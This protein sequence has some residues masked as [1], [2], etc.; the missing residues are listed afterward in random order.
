MAWLR[1]SGSRFRPSGSAP[2]TCAA[3]AEPVQ[4]VE[5]LA[6]QPGALECRPLG[7]QRLAQGEPGLVLGQPGFVLGMLG[8]G[9]ACLGPALLEPKLVALLAVRPGRHGRDDRDEDRQSRGQGGQGGHGGVALAPPPDP[10]GG[11]D[12]ARADR[13]ALQEPP[14]LVRSSPAVANRS[15]GSL[16]RALSTIVSRSRGIRRS[17]C[18]SGAGGWW[19]IWSMS[20][21]LVAH[22]ANAGRS[23][24][25]S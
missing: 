14:Q 12:G 17:C 18:R 15:L 3:R 24:S 1:I 7:D 19:V 9:E 5:P 16:A 21:S 6:D 4:A 2:R 25:I 22:S 11:R 10:L 23:V 13:P 20:C 8:P